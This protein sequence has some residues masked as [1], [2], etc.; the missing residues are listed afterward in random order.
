[1]PDLDL[2]ASTEWDE[3]DT[4][5]RVK[6]AQN[7]TYPDG[8]EKD[9]VV[10]SPNSVEIALNTKHGTSQEAASVYFTTWHGDEKKVVGILDSDGNLRIAGQL[11]TGQ[12]DLS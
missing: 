4:H 2:G 5:G 12:H 11:S 3:G 10:S 6:L 9:T 7:R 1:M 8:P